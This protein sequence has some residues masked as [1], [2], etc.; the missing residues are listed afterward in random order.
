[1]SCCFKTDHFRPLFSLFSP[2]NTDLIQ[3]IV[4][5]ADDWIW[6]ADLWCKKQLIYQDWG[7]TTA[8]GISLFGIKI[9]HDFWACFCAT[10]QP[11]YQNLFWHQNGV[12]CLQLMPVVGSSPLISK[13]SHFLCFFKNLTSQKWPSISFS[14]H[15]KGHL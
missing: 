9:K 15:W 6:T 11:E 5:F 13:V 10:F 1:M 3:L 7:T 2:F 12:S 8:Q 4:K 14:A